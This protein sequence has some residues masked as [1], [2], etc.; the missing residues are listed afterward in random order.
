MTKQANPVF[1]FAAAAN[2]SVAAAVTV[3][4]NY[5][6]KG[7]L[8]AAAKKNPAAVLVEHIMSKAAF[9][10]AAEAS[11][12][13]VWLYFKDAAA[14]IGCAALAVE[15]TTA[16]AALVGKTKVAER[17]ATMAKQAKTLANYA[18]RAESA[19]KYGIAITAD[20]TQAQLDAAIKAAN[21]ENQGQ[22]EG[23]GEGAGGS[24]PVNPAAD[25]NQAALVAALVAA[26]AAIRQ[27]KAALNVLDAAAD[28]AAALADR[29]KVDKAAAA[30]VANVAA[31]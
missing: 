4:A 1:V 25:E 5:T 19:A 31:M 7:Q 17:S 23:E 29:A 15:L 8:T 18:S 12:G 26:A 16:R 28:L 9:E 6:A 3:A 22:G 21:P 14:A 2:A 24:N 11:K 27:G 30:A 10:A 20:M 13:A